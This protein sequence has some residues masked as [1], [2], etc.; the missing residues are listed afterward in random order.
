V[1]SILFQWIEERDEVDKR[2]EELM[3]K[4]RG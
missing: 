2:S 4:D 1:S 3:R